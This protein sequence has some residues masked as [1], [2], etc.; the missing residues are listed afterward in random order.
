MSKCKH[1]QFRVSD[2]RD[3]SI[4][5]TVALPNSRELQATFMDFE[6]GTIW[7][8]ADLCTSMLK[9]VLYSDSVEAKTARLTRRLMGPSWLN[10][11]QHRV[12]TFQSTEWE[13]ITAN[14]YLL[15]GKLSMCGKNKLVVFEVTDLDTAIDTNG[16]LTHSKLQFDG[17]IKLSDFNLARNERPCDFGSEIHITGAAVFKSE[18]TSDL[19]QLQDSVNQVLEIFYSLHH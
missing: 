6:I 9:M 5:F 11:R 17:V 8:E 16:T 12:V 1:L 4:R 3:S 10:V 7:R 18:V 13:R 15:F 2:S 14:E 19:S